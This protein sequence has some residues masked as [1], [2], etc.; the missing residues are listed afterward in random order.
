MS[1][2]GKEFFQNK[3]VR[4]ALQTAGTM[5]LLV[6][7]WGVAYAAAGN[8]LLLPSLW[9]CLKAAGQK[10][11]EKTFW[12][13][14]FST[15]L[16]VLIAF[17]I[18]AFFAVIFAMI[19]YLL[20]LFGKFFSKIT[21]AFR[22]LPTL[23]VMLILLVWTNAS[24][25]PVAVAFLSLFPMLYAGYLAALREVDGGLI[26]MSAVYRV[27]LKKQIVRLYL[28]AIAPYALRESTAAAS[29]ALKLVVSAEVL[30]NTYKSLGGLM[31]E[32]KLYYEMPALFALVLLTFLTGLTLEGLGGLISSAVERRVK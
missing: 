30:A 24:V 3:I 32:A 20:P 31:Q 5:A 13:G 4:G 14:F 9:D 2:K 21:A 28:P 7:L 15:L 25:A 17:L 12:T 27:S 23:A 11:V 29:F 6:V 22:T 8:E 1:K 26:E 10:L 18:S 19:S 16:R